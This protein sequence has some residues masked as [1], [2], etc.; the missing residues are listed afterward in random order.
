LGWYYY[1]STI[2]QPSFG[3]Y[4]YV[5]TIGCFG[6]EFSFGHF[7]C[8]LVVELT[9]IFFCKHSPLILTPFEFRT[10]LSILCVNYIILNLYLIIFQY[11]SL[12]ST[13]YSTKSYSKLPLT[14]TLHNGSQP[15]LTQQSY[16]FLLLPNLWLAVTWL[17][18]LTLL[19]IFALKHHF[20][21]C[22]LTLNFHISR[23]WPTG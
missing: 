14:D 4:Y 8:T 16:K 23:P 12:L 6:V 7:L 1:V 13:T 15:S 17:L 18:W 10:N 3:W 22:S 9:F 19:L 20:T 11:C 21:F 5:S 2:H